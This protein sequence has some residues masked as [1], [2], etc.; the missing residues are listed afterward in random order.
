M[1]TPNCA[2]FSGNDEEAVDGIRRRI[3][4]GESRT[5][6]DLSPGTQTRHG[7]FLAF[8]PPALNHTD[9]NTL[10]RRPIQPVGAMSH[11]LIAMLRRSI[12][13]LPFP[14]FT[15]MCAWDPS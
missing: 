14:L 1:L 5:Y 11:L 2:F 15:I 6:V 7:H 10:L 9:D 13:S 12:L 4:A 3:E 8:E